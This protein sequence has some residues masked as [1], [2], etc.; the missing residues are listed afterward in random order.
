[1]IIEAT[2]YHRPHGERETVS[3]EIRDDLAGQW[4]AV[5]DA[6]LHLEMEVLPCSGLVSVTLTDRDR[7]DY[8]CQVKRNDMTVLAAVET[9]IEEFDPA[10]L[11][12]WRETWDAVEQDMNSQNEEN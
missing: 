2:Q 1:M 9:M 10:A 8:V 6:G 12:A 11:A 5:R 4:Q 3:G 7:A